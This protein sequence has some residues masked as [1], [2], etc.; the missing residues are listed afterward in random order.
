MKHI[1]SA[2]IGALLAAGCGN[3][4]PSTLTP[5]ASIAPPSITEVWENTV[6]VGATRF[7]SFSVAQNGT[8]NVTLARVIEGGADSASQLNLGT[9]IPSGPTCSAT[10]TTA[11][12]AGEGPHISSTSPPGVYCVKVQDAGTLSAPVAFRVVIAHP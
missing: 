6:A 4:A 5:T 7:Y 2:V 9:G 3:D 10:S 11:Y 8:V 1:I 12:S